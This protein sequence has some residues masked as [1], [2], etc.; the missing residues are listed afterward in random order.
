M[1]VWCRVVG[2]PCHE[3]LQL[4]EAFR[5]RLNVAGVIESLPCYRRDS[6][7][8]RGHRHC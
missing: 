8:F 4:L 5:N 3:V 7:L 6:T 1:D 2:A